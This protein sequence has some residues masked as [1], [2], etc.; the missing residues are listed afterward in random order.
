M[1]GKIIT[2]FAVKREKFDRYICFRYIRSFE[3]TEKKKG[4]QDSLVFALLWL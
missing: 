1:R 2:K 3:K 4:E